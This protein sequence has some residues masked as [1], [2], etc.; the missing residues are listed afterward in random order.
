M[1][2]LTL[3][4]RLK[5]R[6]VKSL[7]LGLALFFSSA[8][9]IFFDHKIY[10]W[11]CF[12]LFLS[13]IFLVIS[14]SAL[15]FSYDY[16]FINIL[17]IDDFLISLLQQL[18][19]LSS[20]SIGKSF[21]LL[22]IIVFI[23]FKN[24]II[25]LSTIYTLK[26]LNTPINRSYFLKKII[27]WSLVELS[28][29]G[30]ISYLGMIT[31]LQFLWAGLTFFIVPLLLTTSSSFIHTFYYSFIL[32][33]KRIMNIVSAEFLFETVVYGISLFLAQWDNQSASIPFPILNVKTYLV[34]AFIF[35]SSS[36]IIIA[37]TVLVSFLYTLDIK[38]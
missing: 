36:L 25:F 16:F 19:F 5:L 23:N 26:Q 17:Q 1:R 35:Y 15:R 8:K 31:F 37:Q 4:S 18:P 30:I 3:F 28:A 20:D 29:Y 24:F 12:L 32:L 6:H 38:D 10:F 2:W 21:A 34:I 14:L 7:R 13:E 22:S 33:K 9:T 27:I 11:F